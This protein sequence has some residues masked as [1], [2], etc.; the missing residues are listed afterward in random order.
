M[1]RWGGGGIIRSSVA[2]RY[3]DGLTR[4]AGS[5]TA[6][7]SA[8]TPHGVCESAMKAACCGGRS[9]ANEGANFSRSRNRKPS[10]GGRRGGTVA[11]RGGSAIK[12]LTDSFLSGANAAM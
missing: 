5:D 8:S 9:A 1:A 10:F 6:P 11:Q 3:Q 4:H 2:T 7:L 12:V